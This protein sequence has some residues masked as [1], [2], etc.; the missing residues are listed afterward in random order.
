MS[1]D[2]MSPAEQFIIEATLIVFRVITIVYVLLYIKGA[3]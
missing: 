2:N 1:Q 3:I